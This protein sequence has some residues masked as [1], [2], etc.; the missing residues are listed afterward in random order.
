MDIID[1]PESDE[2][3]LAECDVETFRAS[4]KGGQHVNTTDSAVRLTHR[5]TGV[6]VSCQQER[7]Q[8]RN[9]ATCLARLREKLAKLNYTPPERLPTAKPRVVKEEILATKKHVAE[10]KRT[11]TKV[12][13]TIDED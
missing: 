3:L 11:R 9:K 1:I 7:S 12:K 6:V 5:A 8:H 4:G 2:K 10:K 13:P